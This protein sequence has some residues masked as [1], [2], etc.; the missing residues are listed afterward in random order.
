MSK[1]S[2]A[3]KSSIKRIVNVQFSPVPKSIFEPK[4]FVTALYDDD[5]EGK[6]FDYFSDEVSFTREELIGLTR[7]EAMQ[8]LHRKETEFCKSKVSA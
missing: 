6:L 7:V 4:P 8:L 5:S 3:Q 1:Q 2:K